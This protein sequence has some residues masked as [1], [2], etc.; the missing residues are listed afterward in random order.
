MRALIFITMMS[1][2]SI[3]GTIF[4]A[5]PFAIEFSGVLESDLK[6]VGSSFTALRKRK[7]IS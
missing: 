1:L 6:I 5:Q 7:N 3:A 2:I 4:V